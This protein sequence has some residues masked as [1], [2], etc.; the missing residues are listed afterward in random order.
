MRLRRTTYRIGP[1]EQGEA[2]VAAEFGEPLRRGS[3]L[4]LRPVMS[5]RSRCIFPTLDSASRALLL[6]QAGPHAARAFTVFP[7]SP[8]LVVSSPQFPCDACDCRCLRRLAPAI[9]G[10]AWTRWA[11]AGLH[12][13]TQGSWPPAFCPP[14]GRSRASAKKLAL[15]LPATCVSLT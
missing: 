5:A 15:G 2:R 13:Q 14:S 11:T 9:V 12:A 4:P 3:D 8:E 1:S 10:V 7:T 6:S